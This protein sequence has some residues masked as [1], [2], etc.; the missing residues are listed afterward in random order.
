MLLTYDCKVR[1]WYTD[2]FLKVKQNL[3]HEQSSNLSPVKCIRYNST[4]LSFFVSYL[5][6][7]VVDLDSSY[8]VFKYGI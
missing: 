8:C 7:V 3:F 5:I 1:V 4:F 2:V 6:S